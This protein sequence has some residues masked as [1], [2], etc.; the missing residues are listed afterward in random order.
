MTSDGVRSLPL[1]NWPVIY[2]YSVQHPVPHSR[3]AAVTLVPNAIGCG[4]VAHLCYI[5]WLWQW[6]TEPKRN[7]MY[8]IFYKYIGGWSSFP[9]RSS[10]L[11]NQPVSVLP[12]CIAATESIW[13]VWRHSHHSPAP[14]PFHWYILNYV[15][16]PMVLQLVADFL[17]HSAQCTA[18]HSF[19]LATNGYWM[20]K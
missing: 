12:I 10:Q 9:M 1:D 2:L 15:W 8:L 17:M 16:L 13:L 4:M 3:A 7:A 11:F 20:W 6:Y 5:I 14:D 18:V 19:T